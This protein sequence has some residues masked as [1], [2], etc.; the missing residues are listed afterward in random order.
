MRRNLFKRN[1]LIYLISIMLVSLILAGSVLAQGTQPQNTTSNLGSINSLTVAAA[2]PFG[3]ETPAKPANTYT[4]PNKAPVNITGNTYYVSAKD[5]SD[6]NSGTLDKPFATISKAA[7]IM[8]AGD[9]CMIREGTYR[10]TLKPQNS[11]SSNKPILFSSYNNE[12][13]VIS[14][15]DQIK[16]FSKYKDNTYQAQMDW[17]M[18]LGRDQVF[19]DG[20]AVIQARYPN[21]DIR[22]SSPV[23]YSNLFPT[24]GY[25]YV[26]YNFRNMVKSPYLTQTSKDYWKGGIFV[27]GQNAVW[28][29]QSAE[30]S[31]SKKGQITLR[32]M[33]SNWWFPLP[34]FYSAESSEG[35]ITNSLNALDTAGE[36]H[37]Q[38]DKLYIWMPKSDDP[39]KHKV[40]AKKR[41]LA[42]DLTDKQNI[43]IFGIDTFA[44]SITMTRSENC[45]FDRGT[46]TYTSHFQL[47]ND[48]RSGFIDGLANRSEVKSPMSGQVG[49]YISG[50]N[51][52]FIN[53]TVRYSAG[54]GLYLSGY[55]TIVENNIIHDVGYACTYLGGI[56][57]TDEWNNIGS[58]D[59][60]K[61]GNYKIRYN[62][63]YNTG[64]SGIHL[65][66]FDTSIAQYAG[67]EIS[68]NQ[69]FNTVLF[70]SDGGSF[71]SY[72]SNLGSNGKRTQIHSN[73]FW[74]CFRKSGT[75]VVYSDNLVEGID[76]G[77]N[78]F[79]GH[80]YANQS[81]I[82]MKFDSKNKDNL[83]KNIG[84]NKNLGVKDILP[85][86][87]PNSAYPGGKAYFTGA[88][89]GEN[90]TI[91]AIPT[92]PKAK[93]YI[94]P[95]GEILRTKWTATA[96]SSY[97]EYCAPKY[98]FDKDDMYT[99]WR[100][101]ENVQSPSDWYLLDM[102][103][104]QTF[105]RIIMKCSGYNS[106]R[107]YIVTVSQDGKKWSEPVGMGDSCQDLL[108]IK[109]FGIQKA[110]YIKIS[111]TERTTDG[112]GQMWMIQDLRVY[113]Q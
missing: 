89:H 20:E 56:F 96:S 52:K 95:T 7:Y 16:D 109:L 108:D 41:L 29:W 88:M 34:D 12:K 67:S 84:G 10:E 19:V 9:A 110:R 33:T 72:S 65:G 76:F 77:N 73:L 47:F 63:I 87:L 79:W 62:T 39:A 35:Y 31:S 49:I 86:D 5:G 101:E 54:A 61:L 30:I 60:I 90:P 50:K 37:N 92:L 81:S 64:R 111:Q 83:P 112:W 46:A 40:E 8:V 14:G 104:V 51:N 78:L 71:Y 105:S 21:K 43:Y 100:T 107:A 27:G 42:I 23:T 93:P 74:N 91:K 97:D 69:I 13:V 94:A 1:K 6:D 75:G 58:K 36:W 82:L 44:A 17:S 32:N 18:G 68:F 80:T 3:K 57:A 70:T 53:S 28:A 99:Y 2:S 24:R 22:A 55:G 113:K 26:D 85:T 4:L 45:S 103:S 102:K 48:A 106:P 59:N 11:G 38:N 25:F 98:A 15:A 66:S